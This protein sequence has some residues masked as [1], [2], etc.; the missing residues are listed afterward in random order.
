[1]TTTVSA[2]R[3]NVVGKII[4]NSRY[5]SVGDLCHSKLLL[6]GTSLSHNHSQHQVMDAFTQGYTW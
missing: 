6:Y 2:D 4:E 5:E 3:N 1:M